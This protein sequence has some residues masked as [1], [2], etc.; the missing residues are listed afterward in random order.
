MDLTATGIGKSMLN[1]VGNLDCHTDV[2]Q[3][4]EDSLASKATGTLLK[5]ASSLWR[6]ASWL[7]SSSKGTCFDQTE[8]TVHEYMN[9]LRDNRSAQRLQAIL[10]KLSD[11]QSRF[12]NF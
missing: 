12:S 7:V 6:W 1:C 5:R 11:L 4:L 3:V 8:A 10:L 9:H 2:L